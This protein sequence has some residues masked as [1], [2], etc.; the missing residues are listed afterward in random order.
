MPGIMALLTDVEPY[1]VLQVLY[2]PRRWLR[3]ARGPHDIPYLTVYARTTAGRPITVVIHHL[4]GHDSMIV[5]ARS[6]TPADIALFEQ[7]EHS[8]G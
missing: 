6:M 7:W 1:E 8:H 2:S 5:A 3:N 4:G